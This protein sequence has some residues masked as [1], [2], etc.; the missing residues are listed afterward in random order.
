[1]TRAT[2]LSKVKFYNGKCAEFDQE[3]FRRYLKTKIANYSEQDKKAKRERVEK[4]NYISVE[5]LEKAY[6][7]KCVKCG[8]SFSY[9]VSSNATVKCDLTANRIDNELPHSID[10]IEPMCVHCN[11]SLSNK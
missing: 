5:W 6:A 9:E 8:C 11:C 1:M 2:D 4:E 7:S 3:R 10:N